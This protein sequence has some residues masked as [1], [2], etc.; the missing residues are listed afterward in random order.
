[1]K[2]NVFRT[3]I[4]VGAAVLFGACKDNTP[5][6]PK[7][8]PSATPLF[9]INT[10]QNGSGACMGDDA[11]AFGA[12]SGMSSAG[13]LNCTSQDVDIGVAIVTSYSFD[14]ITFTNL[15]PECLTDPTLSQCRIQCAP[16]TTVFAQ[17]QAVV[18]NNAQTR[19]DFG[20]WI[21][22]DGGNAVTGTC[23]QFNL[24][25]PANDLTANKDFSF[26][27]TDSDG[28]AC[29]DMVQGATAHVVLGLRTFPCQEGTGTPGIVSVGACVG[30][31][32]SIDG[33]GNR[34]A[35]GICPATPPG[36]AQGFR[37][38]ATP[39]TKAKCKCG[40]LQL[41]IDVQAALTLVKVVTNDNGGTSTVSSFPLTATGPSTISG[42]SGT[43]SV[44]VRTVHAGSYALTEQT[45]A[46]Y[47]ASSWACTGGT[48]SGSNIAL[49][50]GGSATCTIIN[51]DNAAH[52]TL[53]K[54]VTN[55]NGGTKTTAD[56]PLTATGPSTISGTSGSGGVTNAAV[57]A[58]T[59][60]LSETTAAN[61]TAGA[62]SCSNGGGAS[63]QVTVAFASSV[64]CTI[65]NNDNSSALTL[66]KTVTNDNG[67]T[68]TTAN[69]PLTATGPS[70]ITGTSGAGSVTNAP[71]STGTYTLSETTVANYTAGTWSCSNGG[72]ASSQVTVAFGSSVTCTINNNDNAPKLTL[73]KTVTNDNGGTKTTADFP[74][75]ATG[76]STISGA[77]GAGSVTNASVNAGT[78]T[79]SEQAQANYTASAWSCSN[80]GGASSQVTVAFGS[81]V[82]CT[83]NNN[84]NTS[85]L[86]LVKTVTNDNGGTATTANFP[87]TATGPSTITGTSGAGSVTN[88]AVNAGTYTLSETTVANYTA[89]A[90]SCSNGGGASSQVTVVFGTSVTCTINNNDNKSKLTLVKTVTND[91]GGTKTAADFPLTATGPSTITGTSGATAVTNALVN[92]GAYTLSETTLT[93]YTPSA[94][95]CSN[96][97]GASSQVTVA[98]GSSVTCT[99][100]NNDKPATLTVCKYLKGA[101][102]T[103]NYSSTGGLPSGGTFTLTPPGAACTP[104]AGTGNTSDQ[105]VFNNLSAG[106]FTITEGTKTGYILTDLSCDGTAG[107]LTTRTSS[108]T[109][110]LGESKTCQFTNEQ[111]VGG[112][113]RTQG[114]WATHSSLLSA[115][116]F[117]TEYPPGSGLF[118]YSGLSLAD[119]TICP[120]GSPTQLILTD[121]GQVLG[122][123]WAGISK[124]VDGT[125]RS[126]LDQARM[127]LLQQLLAAISNH[128]AFGSSPSGSI[129]IDQAKAAFCTGTL[130]QV[131]D[132]A[133]AMAAFNTSGDNGVFTPGASA[134]G[135]DA[136]D[137]AN[138]GFWDFLIPTNP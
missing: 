130:Q 6:A 71:V 95:S 115:V 61:Y 40:P 75:T 90:W 45:V 113:T 91:N 48:Q 29:G 88:A 123:F 23:D 58:G 97:G 107:N 87:L 43:T 55:D 53:V 26:G 5:I 64:T 78:Y 39:E 63:S 51:N 79:L 49:A 136:K 10:P 111:Q 32:N 28:D 126:D 17:T 98:F 99:I 131:K 3:C 38:G 120:A 62:W 12:T 118:P 59:Y 27:V 33:G 100:N 47:T 108:V 2:H 135:K 122:G 14:G 77:S 56:F 9:G 8:A 110:A 72:G 7:V 52:L 13:D 60:T 82:T 89:G 31:L 104:P 101:S 42:V 16:G 4:L 69:F 134:N 83:I 15:P 93:G 132:A 11:F 24:V 102:T 127:Q 106:T 128:A 105:I 44:T 94:W 1:M 86:T 138:I 84:D 34:P 114:F 46:N 67:G 76:P 19:Y 22:T 137:A 103:F 129:S 81:S 133:A 57:N 70:T 35:G 96:G 66:V 25:T 21:A 112:T 80:G 30:W 73:V 117:G 74:L 20:V 37:D 18:E 68:A 121:I 85:S 65:N 50:T 41:P 36:G 92:A 116:W 125:K 119:R 109:L 124:T 54:T